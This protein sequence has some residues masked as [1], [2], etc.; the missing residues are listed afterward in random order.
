MNK[1][2]ITGISGTGKTTIAKELEQRGFYTI[3]ID[4][5]PNLC[6]WI[7]KETKEKVNYEAELNKE[8]IDAHDWVCDVEYLNELIKK[9]T[10]PIFV[11][12]LASNQKDFI[13]I[14][15]K[16]LLLQCSPETFISRIENRTDNDFGK[17]KTAQEVILSWYQNFENTMLEKGAISIDVEKP[18]NEVIENI[19]KQ[20]S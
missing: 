1:I 13:H 4:E 12:G 19:I 3:S 6:V 10:S 9:G 16:T 11:L 20:I 17:D 7:H 15:D 8:F 5:V 18:L 2:Y 14:F